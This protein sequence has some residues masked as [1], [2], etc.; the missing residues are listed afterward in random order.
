VEEAAC[1]PLEGVRG[2]GA[3]AVAAGAAALGEG[4][5]ALRRGA[6]PATEH[7]QR[8][9]GAAQSALPAFSAAR[10][11]QRPARKRSEARK[12]GEKRAQRGRGADPAICKG[13]ALASVL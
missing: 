10:W 6:G 12:A 8:L 13:R 11:S 1:S 4:G 9:P 3:A 2:R 7:A 5:R